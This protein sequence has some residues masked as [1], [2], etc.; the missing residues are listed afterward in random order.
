MYHLAFII[1]VLTLVIDTFF[2]LTVLLRVYQKAFGWYFVA[3]VFGLILW[4]VGDAGLLFARDATSV[5]TFAELFYIVPMIT[6]ISI[7]FF[8]LS[9]PEDRPLP[10]WAPWLAV[11]PLV[12]LSVLFLWRF[13]FFIHDITITHSLNVATPA[14]AG[15]Y[16]YSAFFSSFFILVYI[17]FFIKLRHLKG[18]N[19]SQVRYTFVGVLVGSF[20]ALV[21][22]LSLPTLGVRKFIWLGPFFTLFFPTSVAAAIVRH[23]LF[24]IRFVLARSVGY[25]FALTGLAIIYV[26]VALTLIN[27]LLFR[28]SH[29]P[30]TQQLV[31]AVLAAILAF[32]FQPLRRFLE[33]GTNRVF[34]RDAYD[35]QEFFDSFNKALVS[36]I[37]L[38]D[39]LQRVVAVIATNLKSQYALI[40]VKDGEETQRIIGTQ[41][42]TFSQ[43]EIMQVRHIT[44]HIHQTVIMAD[45]IGAEHIHLQQLLQKNDVAVLARITDDVNKTHEGLGYIALGPK[46]SGNPYTI[47]DSRVLETATNELLI[48]I[49]NALRFEEIERFN[50]TLQQ[51]VEEAIKKLRETNKRLKLLDETKDDFISMAS[52]QL[53]TPLTA[54]KGYISLVL[55]GDA[56]AI[57]PS[58]RK[59]LSQAFF[60]SQRMVYLI[61]DLL[62]VSRLKTGRFVIEPSV[63][64]LADVVEQEVA[65][66]VDTAK[67]RKL[68]LT[69]HK[70]EH[71]PQ[72]MLDETK[73]RQVIMN[74]IDN[75]IY[76]T[77]AGGRID[78]VLNDTGKSVELHVIDGG[79]GVPKVEQHHLFTKFYRAKNAQKARPDGTGLGLFMAKK[80]VVAQGGA[81][82]FTSREGKGSTF[83]FVFPKD[84]HMPPHPS[85]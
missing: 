83:G 8:A 71:F 1:L 6:P 43:E 58:Q 64:N 75:A 63:V 9:F 37:D 57:K 69:Y 28:N 53:R 34:Y 18:A 45:N 13:N 59:L 40:G 62:N 77:L 15:F 74:F 20:L 51:K 29:V 52:H 2:G 84:G 36:T 39:L 16:I 48:A 80:V 61:A 49:Q 5:H 82:I 68:E 76:Y 32:G 38:D 67:G 79:I 55:D 22:N 10:K 25:V 4:V 24:D 26:L 47:Q 35:P 50:V 14:K 31:Y 3:T 81:I 27:Q 66:L 12:I 78:V 46:K 33:K 19:R 11:P 70:P 7:W 72:L 60:S 21:S 17:A 23:R 30:I 85:A 41:H 54:V 44:P 42:R 65:Q 73:I 56:G